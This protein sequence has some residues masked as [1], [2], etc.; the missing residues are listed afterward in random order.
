MCQVVC[1]LEPGH[2]GGH[3]YRGGW[4]ENKESP[5]PPPVKFEFPDERRRPMTSLDGLV[6]QDRVR[7]KQNNYLKEQRAKARAARG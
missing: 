6:G 5:T 3:V 7:A 4:V 1:L 2:A